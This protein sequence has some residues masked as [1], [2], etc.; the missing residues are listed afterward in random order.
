MQSRTL[1]MLMGVCC[2]LLAGGVG[3][4][5][6]P[7]IGTWELD[8]E[9][10]EFYDG[11]PPQK[12]TRIYENRGDGLYAFTMQSTNADGSEFS[13]SATYRYDGEP[14]P[15]TITNGN[16]SQVV[17][18]YIDRRTVQYTLLVDGEET[19]R[20]TKRISNNGRSFSLRVRITLPDGDRVTNVLMFRKAT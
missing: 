16:Q 1:R 12:Q 3:A 14:H 17:Y 7:F 19:Q 6:N 15:V 5:T 18:E 4:Q 10:S 8:L 20:G 2:L 9:D 11:T 13:S